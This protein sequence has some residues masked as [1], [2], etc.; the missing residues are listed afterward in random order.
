MMT[1][2]LLLAKR[3][4]LGGS[5]V[6]PGNLQWP[7]LVM[8]SLAT[9]ILACG[10][11]S[12]DSST[13]TPDPTLAPVV[14]T[15]LEK[16]AWLRSSDGYAILGQDDAGGFWVANVH[17]APSGLEITMARLGGIFAPGGSRQEIQINV[18]ADGRVMEEAW[19]YVPWQQE[20]GAQ[21]TDYMFA[22]DSAR[23]VSHLS[24]SDAVEYRIL[25]GTDPY[26]VNFST[27]GL[28]EHV[29]DPESFCFI[30]T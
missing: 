23:V 14:H 13:A 17:C 18:R 3:L 11:P 22:S 8:V 2:N 26:L 28:D 6:S 30:G 10:D 27:S 24:E 16:D 12:A 21:L 4:I 29:P 1:P 19:I 9:L 20:Q 7:G 25:T 5:R 15:V